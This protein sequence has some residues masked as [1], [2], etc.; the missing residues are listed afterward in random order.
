MKRRFAL[1]FSVIAVCSLA[2]CSNSSEKDQR[3]VID[4]L[5]DHRGYLRTEM[6]VE[7]DNMAYI[8][9]PSSSLTAAAV[10]EAIL[11]MRIVESFRLT[12]PNR[13]ILDVDPRVEN[14]R[15]LGVWIRFE[16]YEIYKPYHD[17]PIPTPP[18]TTP[19]P[20]CPPA[21]PTSSPTST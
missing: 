13:H 20:P 17:I 4:R 19:T 21:P 14:S 15:L 5:F 1:L 6:V 9:N 12:Y 2:G 10:R 18:P 8:A 3:G 16:E 11:P 7:V